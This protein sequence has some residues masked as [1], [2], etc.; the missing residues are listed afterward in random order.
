MSSQ[1]VV[2]VV[3]FTIGVGN[4]VSLSEAL[5]QYWVRWGQSSKG[6]PKYKLTENNLLNSRTCYLRTSTE[7]RTEDGDTSVPSSDRCQLF[8]G[9]TI[10]EKT[11]ENG[12]R[13]D[14]EERKSRK[15]SLVTVD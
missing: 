7:I 15:E 3:G 9:L 2:S 6:S 4:S 1:S 14:H 12:T 10:E 13:I 8:S 5:L 11:E